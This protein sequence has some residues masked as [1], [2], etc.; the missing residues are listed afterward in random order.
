MATIRTSYTL[1]I[2]I[3]SQRITKKSLEEKANQILQKSVEK[4]LISLQINTPHDFYHQL[5]INGDIKPVDAFHYE[6]QEEI[7]KKEYLEKSFY[8]YIDEVGDEIRYRIY[9]ILAEIEQR[10][11]AFI[12]KALAE[13]Q[14]FGKELNPVLDKI[15]KR[16]SLRY[17]NSRNNQI[18]PHYLEYYL[19]CTDFKDLIEFIN[20][21]QPLQDCHL[22]DDLKLKWT[23]NK[24]E[25]SF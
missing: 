7:I 2:H 12:S 16:A 20:F 4:D 1:E 11:R 13:I 25:L 24:K 19:E 23:Q 6:I 10:F 14:H 9:P 8:R 17:K 21:K 22:F 3:D 5:V 15:N 18:A